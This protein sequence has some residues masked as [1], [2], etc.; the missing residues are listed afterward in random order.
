[1]KDIKGF[2]GAYRFLSNFYPAKVV[3]EGIE[4]PTS[5]H[6]FQ[7]AKTLDV[8]QRRAIA[9]LTASEAKRV[10]RKL[11]LREDWE[12]IK[13]VTMELILLDKFSRQPLKRQLIAT[14]DAFLEET[15]TWGDIIWGVCR[16]VGSN[17]LG[18]LLMKVREL[19]RGP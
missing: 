14:G 5:E 2:S 8:A 7:A 19:S 1:M 13:L 4:Y 16:G 12:Q 17:H 10:G 18:K 11:Y 3:F 6:A 15:N 9:T